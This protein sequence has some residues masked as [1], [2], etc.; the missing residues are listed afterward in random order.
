MDIAILNSIIFKELMPWNFVPGSLKVKNELL[1][2]VNA[3]EPVNNT[4][5]TAQVR[6]LITEYPALMK[7]LDKQTVKNETLIT[8]HIHS[9]ALPAYSDASSKYYALLISK[10]KLRLYNAFL[11]RS[12]TGSNKIDIVYHTT[13]AL[14][15]IKALV[16]IQS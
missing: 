7:W 3:L 8:L 14:K 16:T 9:S 2:K 12:N 1:R 10:E 11:N 5:L 15:N 13:I 4:E 6:Q